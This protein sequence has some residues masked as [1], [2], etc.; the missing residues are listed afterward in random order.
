VFAAAQQLRKEDSPDSSSM[1]LRPATLLSCPLLFGVGPGST[2]VH[3]GRKALARRVLG[4][5]DL[6]PV[7]RTALGEDKVPV[8]PG[9]V[10]DVGFDRSSPSADWAGSRRTVPDLVVAATRFEVADMVMMM[11]HRRR[12]L[13]LVVAA[14]TRMVAVHRRICSP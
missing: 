13:E 9:T 10:P 14:A 1:P 5:K 7:A 4:H 8:R 6:A 11:G 3:L 2:Q 12:A